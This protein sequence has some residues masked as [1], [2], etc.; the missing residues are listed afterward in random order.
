[1]AVDFKF[2]K[3]IYDY[4]CTL[5]NQGSLAANAVV[6]TGCIV[7][8]VIVIGDKFINL[9]DKIS[10]VKQKNQDISIKNDKRILE[11][12][13]LNLE[14]EKINLECNKL[15]KDSLPPKVDKTILLPDDKEYQEIYKK[16]KD[17]E[18]DDFLKKIR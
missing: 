16:I 3:D 18:I 1:M 10:G 17:K 6:V 7:V 2:V 11:E 15:K 14:V 9:I 8:I 12:K 4:L 5:F 13:K